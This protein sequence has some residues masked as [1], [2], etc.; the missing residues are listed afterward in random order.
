MVRSRTRTKTPL[1]RIPPTAIVFFSIELAKQYFDI[2]FIINTMKLF[3]CD[4]AKILKSKAAPVIN[5]L[6]ELV[7]SEATLKEKK[8]DFLDTVANIFDVDNWV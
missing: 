1:A 4:D 3:M 8:R 5:K 2:S 7:V 6:A